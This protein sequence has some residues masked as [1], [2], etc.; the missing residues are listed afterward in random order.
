MRKLVAILL[1]GLMATPSLAA[2]YE[3][4]DDK[5]VVNFTDSPDKIPARYKGVAR[6]K[7]LSEEKNVTVIRDEGAPAAPEDQSPQSQS[8]GGRNADWWA[9]AIQAVKAE[10]RS[11]E[12]GLP[13]KRQELA[14][15]Q[16]R[17]TLYHKAADRVAI[18]RLTKEID[19]NEAKVKELQEK[20]NE[21]QT[22]AEEAGVPHSVIYR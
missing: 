13:A 14:Q 21:L 8:Y 12:E 10:I 11:I 18:N 20:L 2:V 1:L 4:V 7:D 3:W 6:E 5:G 17:R 22:K 15:V 19:D 9:G 16:R